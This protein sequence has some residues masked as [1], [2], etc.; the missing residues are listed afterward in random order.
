[1]TMKQG[2]NYSAVMF[3]EMQ[4]RMVFNGTPVFAYSVVAMLTY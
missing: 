4:K 2:Y 3:P 1:M